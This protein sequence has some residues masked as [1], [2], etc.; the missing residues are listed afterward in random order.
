MVTTTG[1]PP[2]GR[3]QVQMVSD[4]SV[5]DNRATAGVIIKVSQ[6]TITIDMSMPSDP[7]TPSST[8]AELFGLYARLLAIMALS[9]T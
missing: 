4:G 1:N 2:F 5:R 6:C 3:V 8:R 7:S 9:K